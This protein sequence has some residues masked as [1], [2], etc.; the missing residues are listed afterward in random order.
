MNQFYI[1]IADLGYLSRYKFV[2]MKE[3]R[4]FLVEDFFSAT[5]FDEDDYVIKLCRE[6][7]E[8]ELINAGV[9]Q[10]VEFLKIEPDFSTIY[11]MNL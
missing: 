7:F 4:I 11:S 1:K 3:Y 2:S 9:A 10:E 5:P 8:I 6:E